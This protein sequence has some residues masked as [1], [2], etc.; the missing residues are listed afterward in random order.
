MH[1]GGRRGGSLPSH[2]QDVRKSK[3][4]TET[5]MQQR[6]CASAGTGVS[7]SGGLL[8]TIGAFPGLLH[9][10]D[11]SPSVPSSCDATDLLA[12]KKVNLTKMLGRKVSELWLG[13]GGNRCCA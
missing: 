10:T 13:L 5:R 3:A 11:S 9:T 2:V 8:A 6:P 4:A 1:G 7:A 12:T